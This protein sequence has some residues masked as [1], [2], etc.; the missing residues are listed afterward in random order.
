[1]IDCFGDVWSIY[2]KLTKP[3]DDPI[4]IDK[5]VIADRVMK[6]INKIRPKKTLG[7]LR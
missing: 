4:K 6:D 2:N 5:I 1:M 7:E 3:Y